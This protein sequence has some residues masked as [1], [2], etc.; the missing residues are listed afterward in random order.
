[1]NR[2]KTHFKCPGC[3]L[4]FRGHSDQGYH[5]ANS[6]E[7]NQATVRMGEMGEVVEQI[8]KEI[9]S[10]YVKGQ[11][12][13]KVKV[14]QTWTIKKKLKELK[15][16]WPSNIR[17]QMIKDDLVDVGYGEDYFYP[18]QMLQHEVIDHYTPNKAK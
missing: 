6:H 4:H 18:T 3:G 13:W 1:M 15:Y 9:K 14:G 10:A 11:E 17:I 12:K 16:P 2:Y 7:C 5:L 8:A